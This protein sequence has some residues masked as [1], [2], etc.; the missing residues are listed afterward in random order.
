MKRVL[1]I[2]L[3]LAACNAE[4]PATTTTQAPKTSHQPPSPAEARAILANSAELDDF[5]FTTAGFTTPVDLAQTSEPVRAAAKELASAGW[6]AIRGG[7]VELTAKS[8]SD[9]RFLMRA[10]GILDIVP[11]AKKEMD[12]VTAVRANEDGTVTADFAWHWMPNEV[13]TAFKTGDLYTRFH[14]PRTSKATMIWDGT[15]WSVLK[16][17]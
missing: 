17:E 10:N 9:K 6:I 7:R 5:E 15:T 1:P 3:L 4:S 13:C 16:I 11:L 14:T 12:G 8:R 2:L